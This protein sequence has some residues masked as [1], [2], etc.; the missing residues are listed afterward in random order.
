MVRGR[1]EGLPS[2]KD[3]S[4]NDVSHEVI[5]VHGFE[6]CDPKAP[7]GFKRCKDILT[8]WVMNSTNSDSMRDRVNL[9]VFAFDMCRVLYEGPEVLKELVEDLCSQIAMIR[10]H[11]PQSPIAMRFPLS[12]RDDR[13]N[14]SRFPVRGVI[15]VAHGLGAW[16][17]KAAL[18]HLSAK[19]PSLGPQAMIFVDVGFDA[20]ST[21]PSPVHVRDSRTMK[22]YLDGLA[23]TFGLSIERYTRGGL[24][25]WLNEIDCH[26]RDLTDQEFDTPKRLEVAVS[27]HDDYD[28]I[29][30]C[31]NMWMSKN[32]VLPYSK[33]SFD[34][35]FELLSI[36]SHGA[37]KHSDTQVR[38]KLKRLY[39]EESLNEVIS[40]PQRRTIR[41]QTDTVGADIL[42][43]TASKRYG[44][45]AVPG[46]NCRYSFD[47]SSLTDSESSLNVNKPLPQLP[48]ER[49]ADLDEYFDYE[50][51]ILFSNSLFSVRTP[52][53][54]GISL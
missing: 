19:Q 33:S 46:I 39:L 32:R 31:Q 14:D 4:G 45:V 25:R 20:T 52:P 17:L 11:E 53:D 3:L 50:S 10:T 40:L 15:F 35:M 54:S 29:L 34:R 7:P 13:G 42:P 6:S 16:I 22:R 2:L 48:H 8:S 23:R 41:I 44:F 12:P 36:L 5:L 21:L 27:N 37:P 30:W 49:T 28:L 26:F 47:S 43:N 24:Q 38:E 1:K 51:C 18:C 9:R